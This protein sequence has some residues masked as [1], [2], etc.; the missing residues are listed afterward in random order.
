MEPGFKYNMFDIQAALGLKQLERME[1]MQ[2]NRLRIAA[3]FQEAFGKIDAIDL[4]QIPDYTTHCWHLYVIR[5]VP[6][7]LTI[8]RD[9]FIEELNQRNVG[10]SVHFIPVH[11]MSAYQK[12]FG[13]R[14]GDFPNAEKHF[15]RII[16]LPLYPTLTDEETQYI[17]DAVADIVKQYHK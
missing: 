10:T 11:L 8:D 9:R 3:R 5:I 13:C 15:D 14:E 4:P 6:E 16:S 2:Q 1:E 7:V 17:I 12:R